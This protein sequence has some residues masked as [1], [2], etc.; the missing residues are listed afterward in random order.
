MNMT[1][2]HKA[3][4]LYIAAFVFLIFADA[5]DAASADE[6]V[7]VLSVGYPDSIAKIFVQGPDSS[8]ESCESYVRTTWENIV[9]VCGACWVEDRSCLKVEEIDDLYSA[10]LRGERAAYPYV[11]ATPKGRIIIRGTSENVAVGECER[12]AQAFRSKGYA[13][14]RCVSPR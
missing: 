11:V 9:R 12:L 7:S 8:K 3:A 2:Q 4:M 14:S 13:A 1:P 5:N 6:Y 10:T